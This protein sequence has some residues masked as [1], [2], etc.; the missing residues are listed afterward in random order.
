MTNEQLI[1]QYDQEFWTLVEDKGYTFR[2]ARRILK[3]KYPSVCYDTQKDEWFIDGH[4][5]YMEN[6]K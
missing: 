4:V 5:Y 3:K 6:E 2:K 1:S